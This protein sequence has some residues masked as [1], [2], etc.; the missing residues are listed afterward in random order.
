MTALALGPVGSRVRISPIKLPNGARVAWIGD[1]VV[2]FNHQN[3]SSTNASLASQSKGEIVSAQMLDPR[4][5]CDVWVSAD[6]RGG[7]L[8]SGANQGLTGDTASSPGPS[9][10]TAGMLGRLTSDILP[11]RPDLCVVAGGTNDIAA[12]NSMAGFQAIC[13]LLMQNFIRPV[14]CTIRP[15]PST[16]PGHSVA[17]QQSMLS[18]NAQIRAYA[19]ITPGVMLCDLA[20]AYGCPGPNWAFGP[21]TYYTS[22]DLHPSQQGGY[23]GGKALVAA[24][25]TLIQPG[26]WFLT[27]FWQAGTN[28]LPASQAI[29][30]AGGHGGKAYQTTGTVPTGCNIYSNTTS[31][32]AVS[33][34]ANPDTGGSSVQMQITP[35][36]TG[37][38]EVWPLTLADSL[39]AAPGTYVFGMAE[40]EFDAWTSWG[41]A[42]FQLSEQP[43]SADQTSYGMAVGTPVPTIPEAGR[44]W[45]ITPPLKLD[46]AATGVSPQ[47][48]LYAL[49]D[50]ASGTGTFTIHRW[51]V[52]PMPDPHGPWSS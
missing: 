51:G 32:N 3:A 25:G 6:A 26:N 12:P 21:T 49:P 44:R 18:L 20:A 7:R 28:L 50:G 34:V 16:Y 15:W 42:T 4:F 23:I 43:G 29:F 2:Q 31:S 41:G 10:D 14:L 24:L 13:T 52:F 27:T 22:G 19:A 40:V 17:D 48:T 39:A 36:G 38:Y 47:I 11:L 46:A 8:F 1:S 33:L 5:R 30:T 35:V 37:S 9:T 45:L